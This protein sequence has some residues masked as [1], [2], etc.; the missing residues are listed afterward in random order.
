MDAQDARDRAE[1]IEREAQQRAMA[2]LAKQTEALGK[3]V[4]QKK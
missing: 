4:E 3:L 1:L 2:K